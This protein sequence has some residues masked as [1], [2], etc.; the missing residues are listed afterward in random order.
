MFHSQAPAG[1]APREPT[2]IPKDDSLIPPVND[3]CLKDQLISATP[4]SGACSNLPVRP[5]S[6]TRSGIED[7]PV[8]PDRDV[9]GAQAKKDKTSSVR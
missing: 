4:T 8:S 7:L 1:T 9:V 2:A 5:I 6:P 3:V